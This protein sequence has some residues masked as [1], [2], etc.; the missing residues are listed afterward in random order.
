MR[1]ELAEEA[2]YRRMDQK[3][4]M[5][6]FV[7]ICGIIAFFGVFLMAAGYEMKVCV[8]VITAAILGAGG[9]GSCF[10]KQ[11]RLIMPISRC[12]LEI[13]G[14]C[15]SFVQPFIDGKYESG[16]VYLGEVECLIQNKKADGFYLQ[17]RTEGRSRIQGG[18]EE[19]R[20]VMYISSFGYSR[21]NMAAIYERLKSQ[22]IRT[23]N[24][25]E[26]EK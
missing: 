19:K 18:T 10:W 20:T 26:Y 16:R 9:F 22:V 12:F 1:V 3:D 7:P 21:E 17:I 2:M 6:T 25:Y 13:E 5:I 23:A 24:V 15:F 8:P 11:K 4:R 14:S